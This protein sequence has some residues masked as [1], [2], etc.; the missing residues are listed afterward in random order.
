MPGQAGHGNLVVRRPV[1]SGSKWTAGL[2]RRGIQVVR[3]QYDADAVPPCECRLTLSWAPLCRTWSALAT[4]RASTCC[5]RRSEAPAVTRQA[6]QWRRRQ[7]VGWQ[8]HG[9]GCSSGRK[10]CRAIAALA[11]A[12]CGCFHPTAV[13]CQVSLAPWVQDPSTHGLQRGLLSG[14]CSSS[15][16]SQSSAVVYGRNRRV[17]GGWRQRGSWTGGPSGRF[18]KVWIDQ[19]YPSPLLQRPLFLKVC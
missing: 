9:R 14:G 19:T 8:Q 5:S 2:W 12:Y 3:R 11:V 6:K 1:G 18:P 15:Q 4:A 10:R 13:C 7:A 17:G 16:G